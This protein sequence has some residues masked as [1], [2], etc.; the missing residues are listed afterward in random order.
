MPTALACA[1]ICMRV[2]TVSNG[3]ATTTEVTPYAKPPRHSS[4][5][6]SIEFIFGAQSGGVLAPPHQ[7]RCV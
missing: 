1:L 4:T 3:C 7:N 5:T 2:L 6:L